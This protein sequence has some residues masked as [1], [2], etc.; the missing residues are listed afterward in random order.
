ML[1]QITAESQSETAAKAFFLLGEIAVAKRDFDTAIEHF[2]DAGNLGYAHWQGLAQYE[3]A[4][5]LKELDQTP[6]AVSELET[7]L[8]QHADHPRAEDAKRLLTEWKK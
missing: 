1:D 8:K 3:T 4:R 6:Q 7:M 2:L 5:C